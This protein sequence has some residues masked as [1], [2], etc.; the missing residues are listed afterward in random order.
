[1]ARRKYV[2]PFRLFTGIGLVLG[3]AVA[4]PLLWKLGWHWLLAYLAGIN[5]AVFLLYGYDK[6]AA[7]RE[8]LRVPERVLHGFA[9]AGGTPLAFAAQ[10]VFRHKT[11]KGKFRI[12][13]WSITVVQVGIIA[14]AI[15]HFEL[16]RING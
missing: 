9:F 3:A 12:A 1:M 5:A 2:S 14:W 16:W 10:K 8:K 6:Y 13:F 15:W 11:L 4:V 7:P